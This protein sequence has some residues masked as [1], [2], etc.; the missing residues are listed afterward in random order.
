MNLIFKLSSLNYR[1]VSSF[2]RKQSQEED[3][4]QSSANN[5]ALMTQ[6]IKKEKKDTV[7]V[8]SDK[9]KNNALSDACDFNFDEIVSIQKLY[10]C[11]DDI[12]F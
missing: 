9:L 7:P 8:N 3:N 11:I 6:T 10:K 12:E 5:D 1:F 4:E 2:R